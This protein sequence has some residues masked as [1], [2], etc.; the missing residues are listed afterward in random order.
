MLGEPESGIQHL[1]P[2]TGNVTRQ[3]A[4][5]LLAPDKRRVPLVPVIDPADAAPSPPGH[6][7]KHARPPR[8][9]G[10]RDCLG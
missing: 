8:V 6:S 10:K 3:C 5:H 9:P 7:Q 1:P 4:P 2:P